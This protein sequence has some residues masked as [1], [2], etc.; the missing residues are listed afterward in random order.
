MR[1]VRAVATAAVVLV[2]AEVGVAAG[3]GPRAS[4]WTEVAHT[5]PSGDQELHDAFSPGPDDVWAVGH[6]F[7]SVGGAFEFRTYAQHWDGST[8]TWVPTPDREGAPATNF[9][10][11]VGGSSPSDVWAVGYS[12]NPGQPSVTLVEHWNGSSW[13]IVPSPSPSPSGSY[14]LDVSAASATDA[15]AVGEQSDPGTLTERPVVLHWDG[16]SWSAVPFAAV[17]GCTDRARLTAVDATA[18]PVLVAGTCRTAGGQEQGFVARRTPAGWALEAGA[19]TIPAASRIDGLDRAGTEVWAVGSG[20]AGALTVRRAAGS[21]AVVPTPKVGDAD[22]L[23]AVDGRGARNVWAVGLTSHGTAFAERL[24]MHWNG[25]AWRPVPAGDYSRLEG[26]AFDGTGD[27][28][29][30]GS[31]V[32]KSL[33]LR[34]P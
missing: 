18:R 4:T 30:V 19:G 12:R 24:T 32:G 1:A 3:A 20:P 5:R 6:R 7:V 11:G 23:L 33:I 2:L 14:L 13:S 25:T 22:Q 8:W 34:G 27:V 26:V 21:W 28:W 15:W 10:Y 31:D 9:L 16:G 17:D 29:A